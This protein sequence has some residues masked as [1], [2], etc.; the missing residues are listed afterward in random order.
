MDRP[1]LV[2]CPHKSKVRILRKNS[3][4]STG[5]SRPADNDKI[6]S[7]EVDLS[8]NRHSLEPRLQPESR[9]R[10]SQALRTDNVLHRHD[11]PC[12]DGLLLQ[13]RYHSHRSV[14]KKG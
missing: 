1:N 4:G 5:E 8:T 2:G 10:L 7:V 6:G 9:G 13:G 12:P 11:R 3:C 14:P